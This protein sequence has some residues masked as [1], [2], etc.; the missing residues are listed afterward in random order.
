MNR[1]NNH[2]SAAVSHI[3]EITTGSI[4]PI[5]FFWDNI[6]VTRY[7]KQENRTGE[8]VP[9]DGGDAIDL[10]NIQE[11]HDFFEVGRI[12]SSVELLIQTELIEPAKRNLDALISRF[13]KK[14]NDIH[15]LNGICK[16]DPV[17]RDFLDS[18]ENIYNDHL[19]LLNLKKLNDTNR[20]L[21]EKS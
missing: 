21:L 13:K 7:F 9:S 15:F 18:L 12:N 17:R 2:I 19:T 20:E 16:S 8:L 3:S 14:S 1:E 10:D 11:K 5:D 4:L 6:P